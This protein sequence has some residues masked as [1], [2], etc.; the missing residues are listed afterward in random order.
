MS[1]SAPGGFL[2]QSIAAAVTVGLYLFKKNS[3]LSIL[4]G[5]ACYMML[6]RFVFVG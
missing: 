5:T 6:I 4:G 1:F 3:L 2:P